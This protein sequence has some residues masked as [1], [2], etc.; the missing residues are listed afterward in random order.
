MKQISISI[1]EVA[2]VAA[3][4]IVINGSDAITAVAK[5]AEL[6]ALKSRL[7]RGEICKWAYKKV[8]GEIRICVGTLYNDM[9]KNMTVGGHTPK[10]YFGQFAY[11]E[12]FADGHM[13]WRS[14]RESNFIGTIEN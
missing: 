4:N 6:Q 7:M 12:M 9:V 13:E 11:I 14:F 10:K 2:R 8:S 5:S 3:K 1:N